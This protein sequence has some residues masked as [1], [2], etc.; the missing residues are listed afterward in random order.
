M[1]ARAREADRRHARRAGAAL[2]ADKLADAERKAQRRGTARR[3]RRKD[4]PSGIRISAS[5]ARFGLF[6]W[7]YLRQTKGSF[8]R[9]PLGLELFQIEIM[10]ELLKV[11]HEAWRPITRGEVE[12]LSGTHDDRAEFWRRIHTWRTSDAAETSGWRVHREGALYIAKK[13]GK[14]TKGSGLG[15]FMLG[16]DGEEGAEVYST[17]SAKDQAR[18]VFRQAREM[19]E[20]SPKLLE[21]LELYRNVIEHPSSNSFYT[22]LSADADV[23]EGINPHAVVNDE[24]HA[25]PDRRLY[26]TL[27]SAT[28]ARD[29]PLIF[30]ISNAGVS[31][32][33]K[34]GELTIGGDLYTRGAGKR[35]KFTTIDYGDETFSIIQP[36]KDKPRSFYFRAFEVPWRHRE[37]PSWWKRANPASWITPAKLQEE[38]DIERPRGI[39][40]R[41][42]LTIWSRV[43]KHWLNPG[44]WDGARAPGLKLEPREPVVITVDIGLSYD[45]TALTILSVPTPARGDT[46]AQPRIK[47]RALIWGVHDNPAAPPPPAH[48]LLPEGPIDLDMVEDTIRG[49]A[50]GTLEPELARI[51]ELPAEPVRVVAV[52]GDPHK[53]E[54]Q[55]QHLDA[56]GFNTF[57]FDQGPL[58][59]KASEQLYR[60]TSPKAEHRL[61][62]AGD[63]VLTAHMENATAKD[64]G[65]GRWRL[66]KKAATEKMDAAVSTAMGVYMIGNKDIVSVARPSFSI[67]R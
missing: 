26:D 46:P 19:V 39:F 8:A 54:T 57:R 35:P 64:V 17:A 5:G 27:R 40:Y 3:T 11:E 38:S 14:S 43:E 63:K 42:H 20:A 51:L 53:F 58:M 21:R 28:I 41:Y 34:T 6:T 16:F 44:W 60:S 13:N 31:L 33:D 23:Q 24:V 59:T 29:Q 32:K 65:N 9:K 55:I 61:A 37:N 49:I 47:I 2:A 66:D 67:L 15:L 45:T 7:T 48:K 22:V 56:S 10:S 4:E 62:H 50:K 25:Q 12:L 18:I 1:T 52:G 36:R 30:S